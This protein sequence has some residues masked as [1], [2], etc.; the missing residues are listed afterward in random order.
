MKK[1]WVFD[2]DGTLVDSEYAIKQCFIDVMEQLLP[3][4]TNHAKNAVIGPPLQQTAEIILGQEHTH[5]ADKFVDEFKSVYDNKGVFHTPMYENA[6]E[7]LQQLFSRGDTLTIATN[8]RGIPTRK[9]LHHLD[10]T[11]YFD[12]VACL[13][14]LNDPTLGK[15]RLVQDLQNKYQSHPS[16]WFFVGDTLGDGKVAQH[17]NIPFVRAI[18]GY[19]KSDDWNQVPIYKTIDALTDL[20]HIHDQ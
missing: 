10:W 4:R 2:F 1:I 11:H 19:G 20:L 13:D 6:S 7:V 16:L 15:I 18:Y 12:T 14:D 9:L 5:L 3:S 17:S 8:K